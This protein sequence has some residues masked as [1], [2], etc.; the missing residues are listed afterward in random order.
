MGD[1][2]RRVE[3]VKVGVAETS[4]RHTTNGVVVGHSDVG[5]GEDDVDLYQTKKSNSC[6]LNL[7]FRGVVSSY[8]FQLGMSQGDFI[9]I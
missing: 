2:I 6:E 3:I 4:S 8:N 5:R 9:A 7:M 1:S